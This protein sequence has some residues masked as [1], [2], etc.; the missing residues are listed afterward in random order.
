MG[1]VELVMRARYQGRLCAMVGSDK[2]GMATSCTE[3]Y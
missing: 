3:N 2:K 1:L